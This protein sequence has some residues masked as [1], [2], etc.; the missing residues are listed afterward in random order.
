[1]VK[2]L[3]FYIV[4]VI[5]YKNIRRIKMQAYHKYLLNDGIELFTVV[6][7]PAEK[8]KFPTV[9]YRTPYVDESEMVS[10]DV[11]CEKKLAE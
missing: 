9:I 1:M 6:C 4:W 7:L 10:D 11:I 8:G 5:I 3:L 2:L